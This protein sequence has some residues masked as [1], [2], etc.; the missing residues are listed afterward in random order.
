[1]KIMIKSKVMLHNIWSMHYLP[2]VLI[3]IDEGINIRHFVE[4]IVKKSHCHSNPKTKFSFIKSYPK[5]QF[6]IQRE[7]HNTNFLKAGRGRFKN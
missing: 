2:I 6:K 4:N 5:N 3:I 7:K 1:M